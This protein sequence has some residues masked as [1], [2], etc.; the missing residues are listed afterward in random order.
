MYMEIDR[1]QIDHPGTYGYLLYILGW[2]L[3]QASFQWHNEEWYIL[4]GIFYLLGSFTNA[5]GIGLMMY[6]TFAYLQ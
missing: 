3:L 2:F 4:H 5:I 1:A 6:G